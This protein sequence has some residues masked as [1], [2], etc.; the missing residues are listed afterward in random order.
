ME[1]WVQNH[2]VTRKGLTGFN[3]GKKEATDDRNEV[4]D[5]LLYWSTAAPSMQVVRR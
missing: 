1:Q 5:V 4:W 2:R 3:I